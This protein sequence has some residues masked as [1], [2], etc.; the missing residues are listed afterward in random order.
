VGLIESNESG[1]VVRT[2]VT[3]TDRPDAELAV[4]AEGP[5]SR[6]AMRTRLF[7]AAPE[8]VPGTVSSTVAAGVRRAVTLSSAS[9]VETW[10]M[11]TSRRLAS[12]QLPGSSGRWTTIAVSDD[13]NAIVAGDDRGQLVA[14]DAGLTQ[15]W[16][17]GQLPSTVKHLGVSPEGSLAV[18][19][20][21]IGNVLLLRPTVDRR[22]DVL[23]GTA[24]RLGAEGRSE[25]QVLTP[26]PDG[27]WLLIQ[28]AG[29]V[30]L[31]RLDER[32]LV[33]E[34]PTDVAVV[35]PT[36]FNSLAKPAAAFS[37]D[38]TRFAVFGNGRVAAYEVDS[39][40]QVA[41]EP[42]GTDPV[43]NAQALSAVLGGKG[44]LTVR[45]LG[46]RRSEIVAAGVNHEQ[47]QLVSADEKLRGTRPGSVV[48]LSGS[49][50]DSGVRI[51]LWSLGG[52][53]PERIGELDYDDSPTA[54]AVSPDA[55][56]LVV[57][58]E[59]FEAE[60]IVLDTRKRISLAGGKGTGDWLGT[61]YSFVGTTGLIVQ[62][63]TPDRDANEMRNRL[64]L[65]HADSGALLGE[66]Q[67]PTRLDFPGQQEHDVVVAGGHLALTVRA[68][69]GIAAWELSP[70]SWADSL[71]GT[72]GDL[73]AA[74]QARYQPSGQQG[75]VCR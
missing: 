21:N 55:K 15:V 40:R 30:E 49:Q 23:P 8:P 5:D 19:A 66:W 68:D 9:V 53:V 72:F 20:D 13:G 46:D 25:K 1:Q 4:V 11:A 74:Q 37:P 41:D 61:E 12:R 67:D 71:C 35:E 75:S 48:A 3:A 17:L 60:V 45:R 24:G 47:A 57:G 6:E 52:D 62:Q 51:H 16:S 32:R 58:S 34:Y 22:Y 70:E 38:G 65:W 43:G 73:D 54:L 39:L 14:L 42:A 31:W 26:S 28:R 64:Q 50:E 29:K 69:G 36:V 56:Y 10:D 44:R 7:G 63:V 59:K 18:A 33:R 27:R 2:Y